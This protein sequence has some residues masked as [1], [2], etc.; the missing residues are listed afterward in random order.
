M[1]A[2]SETE[3]YLMRL[4]HYLYDRNDPTLTRRTD[5]GQHLE[6]LYKGD[7]YPDY[8]VHYEDAYPEEE[9]IYNPY[10]ILY[11]GPIYEQRPFLGKKK[12]KN[13]DEKI[14]SDHVSTFDDRYSSSS[15]DSVSSSDELKESEREETC[16]RGGDPYACKRVKAPGTTCGFGTTFNMATCTCFVQEAYQCNALKP[17]GGHPDT[18]YG[19]YN[20][21]PASKPNVSPIDNCKCLTDAEM[22]ALMNHDRGQYCNDNFSSATSDD[23]RDNKVELRICAT[24]T[25]S[26]SDCVRIG[27]RKVKGQAKQIDDNGN[28]DS[29]IYQDSN[30]DP[31]F[32]SCDT[33]SNSEFSNTDSATVETA[34]AAKPK[35]VLEPI[36]G[37]LAYAY[38]KRYGVVESSSDTEE[39]LCFGY[40][41]PH[42]S[43]S[44]GT[45]GSNYTD[46]DKTSVYWSSFRNGTDGSNTTLNGPTSDESPAESLDSALYGVVSDE[47]PV[48]TDSCDS[49]EPWCSKNEPRKRAVYLSTNFG[50][51]ESTV[52]EEEISV[53]TELNTSLSSNSTG[54]DYSASASV[55]DSSSNKSL[56]TEAD[57]SAI[58]EDLCANVLLGEEKESGAWGW[59]EFYAPAY[60]HFAEHVRVSG[61]LNSLGS[62]GLHSIQIHEFGDLRRGCRSTGDEF[63]TAGWTGQSVRASARGNGSYYDW[64]STVELD[65]KNSILGRSVAVYG[66]GDDADKILACGIIQ[67][68]CSPCR[69][70][71]CAPPKKEAAATTTKTIPY[72]PTSRHHQGYTLHQAHD[73]QI[74][75]HHHK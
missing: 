49:D 9:K 10:E 31:R 29:S 20:R 60:G 15:S 38:A 59:I 4:D 36:K 19:E 33:N 2:A 28:E 73:A 22:M 74:P 12:E 14:Q 75:N 37:S 65:G 32:S 71:S 1:A 8:D 40:D 18:G 70:G 47:Y 55:L 23:G 46:P 69:D 44:D 34:A 67:P 39:P 16:A 24:D 30:C 7:D 25:D 43:G 72:H 5:F 50:S 56:D 68:G 21:C 57:G 62:A 63:L 54:R 66:T 58:S 45:Y 53:P 42:Q 52:T 11:S 51:S 26:D 48:F 17:D 6:G 3:Q 27:D 64:S 13:I 61:K 35:K 41:C